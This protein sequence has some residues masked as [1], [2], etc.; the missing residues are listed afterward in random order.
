MGK[1]RR[2]PCAGTKCNDPAFFNPSQK[3]AA[4]SAPF[5]TP[6]SGGDAPAIQKEDAP[7][8]AKEEEKKDPMTEGL[9]ITAEQLLKHKPFTTWLESIYQPQLHILKTELWEEA[10]PG[11]KALMLSFAGVN[12]GMAGLAFAQS[13]ELRKTLSGVN[14]G[15][16]L[17]LIP[18]SPI[19]GF[20]YKLPGA[21]KTDLGLS[22]DFTFNPYL[23]L[24]KNRP[25]FMPSGLTFGL[26][27]TYDL[28]GKG[29][30]NLTG[31][32]FGLNFLDG[33]LGVKGSIF[34]QKSIS[35][36]PLM[37]PGV[38][39]MDPSWIMKQFPGMPDMKTGPG[40]EIMLN[41][42]F[43]KMRWFRRLLGEKK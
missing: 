33:A 2:K 13:P 9:K 11:E 4:G 12:L 17:G 28:S 24:W 6:S 15:A 30:F 23:D 20:K 18:Y 16:P 35:P 34:D 38:D 43:M 10:S 7:G 37:V 5:F 29:G 39:G 1:L 32:K 31:G 21:G 27:S 8:A 22:A 19:E 42:D 14:I 26:D 36:Y 3:S 41:A 40:A 25:S